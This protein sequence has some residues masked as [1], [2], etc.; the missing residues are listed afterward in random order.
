MKRIL[1]LAIIAI[2][3]QPLRAQESFGGLMFSARLDTTHNESNLVVPS[4]ANGVAGFSY[5][6]DTLWFDITANG[7]TGP[8]TSAHIHSEANGSVQYSLVPYIDRNKIKGYL[9]GISMGDGHLQKFLD[10]EYYVNIH[11]ASNPGGEISG[12]ILPEADA[13]YRATLNMEQAGNTNP[14]DKT[15]LGLGSFNLSQDKTE[16]EVNVLVNDLTAAIT[17]AHLHYGAMG[18]SGSVAVPLSQFN[19]GKTYKGVFNTT[20]LANQSAFLDSLQQGKVYINIHTSNFPAGEIRGQLLKSSTLV[21]DT[22]MDSSQ[23]TGTVNP[24]T[25]VNAMGLCNF[26]VNSRLD[27]IRVDIQADQLSGTI[28]GAHFHSGKEGESGPVVMGLTGFIQGNS[29]FAVLTPESPEFSGNLDFDSFVK[30]ALSGD[31]YINLHTALN[32]AGEVR[33]QPASLTRDG[34]IYSLCTSQQTGSVIG[35]D[36]AQGSGFVTMDRN[37]S[38]LHYGIAVSHLGSTLTM[39]HFHA[40][41]PGSNGPV[42]YALPTDS[43]MTGFWNDA[44]FTPEIADKFESGEVYANFH[45]SNNPAGELRGQV[46]V[47]EFCLTNTSIEDPIKPF[48]NSVSIYP[49]PVS[50][51]TTITYILSQRGEVSLSLYNIL[52]KEVSL[53]TREYQE[54]GTYSRNLNASALKEGVY[55]YKLSINGITATTGKVIVNR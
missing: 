20:T 32:P 51:A 26:S 27:T 10:G 52:G 18:S 3:I 9:Q 1:L 11:T 42:I 35:A 45:T 5:H 12:R 49:N 24:G 37:Y 29:V 31:I 48:V 28:T 14:S 36:N 38:N 43:V 46:A 8:I 23:E 34:V 39:D 15:P 17:N 30:K 33:G 55:I 22:W 25:P 21:F 53:I 40:G 41:L 50:S 47:G 44:T 4:S 13:N 54:S 19:L 16:L 2:A 7:L 6:D